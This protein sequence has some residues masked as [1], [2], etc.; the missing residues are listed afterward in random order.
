MLYVYHCTRQRVVC[1]G[2]ALL[3]SIFPHLQLGEN[4]YTLVQYLAI[5]PSHSCNYIRESVD[6]LC[7]DGTDTPYTQYKI[8]LSKSLQKITSKLL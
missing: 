7:R 5:L 6:S 2:I 3:C 4:T 8:K 1:L